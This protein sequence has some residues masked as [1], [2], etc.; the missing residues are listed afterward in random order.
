MGQGGW[1]LRGS[2]NTFTDG[3]DEMSRNCVIHDWGC[4][5]A[6]LA[7]QLLDL[8]PFSQS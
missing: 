3:L 8:I 4:Q 1:E 6:G 2:Q 5:V 7:H